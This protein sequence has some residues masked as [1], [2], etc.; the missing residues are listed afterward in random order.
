M[1]RLAALLTQQHLVVDQV[2]QQRP[3][4]TQGGQPA[5]GLSFARVT[6]GLS[7]TAMVVE[8]GDP[9]EWSRPDEL[10]YAAGKPLPRVGGIF[11]DGFHILLADGSPAFLKVSTPPETLK[12]LITANG[13]EIVDFRK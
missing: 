7:N 8:A 2:Q 6:D 1:G 4:I 13:G 11:G 9:V 10:E 5:K 12:A 3:V